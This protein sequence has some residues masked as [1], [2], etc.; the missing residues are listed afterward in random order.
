MIMTV[1]AGMLPFINGLSQVGYLE[2]TQKQEST[3][4]RNAK[5]VDILIHNHTWDSGVGMLKEIFVDNLIVVEALYV[6]A[7]K[8]II[9]G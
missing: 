9:I 2:E 7:F 4:N 6:Y 1:L 3:T 8:T 5:N